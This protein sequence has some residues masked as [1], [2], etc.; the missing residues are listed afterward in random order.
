MIRERSL[1]EEALGDAADRLA[2]EAT[3]MRSIA[4]RP[5][6]I[7]KVR[8]RVIELPGHCR[9]LATIHPPYIL[10]IDDDAAKRA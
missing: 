4:G 6:A 3:A 8:G 2:L 7:N 5:L 10:R 1:L 9:V